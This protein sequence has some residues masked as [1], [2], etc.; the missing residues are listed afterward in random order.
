MEVA[1]RSSSPTCGAGLAAGVLVL[2]S[3]LFASPVLAQTGSRFYLGALAGP[4]YTDA[5]RVTGS[6]IAVG[7]TGGVRLSSWLG[8][9]VDVLRPSGLLTREYTGTSISFAGP[10]ASRDEIERL[11]VVTRFVNE[12]RPSAII[13]AGAT[14]GLPRPEGRMTPRLF[15]GITNQSARER[16]I[17]EHLSLPPGVTPEQVNRAI[18]PEVEGRSRQLGA[19]TVGGSLA[20]AV[21][22]HVSI[23]PDLRYDYGSI[24]D[25]I[26]NVV[27]SSVRVLWRF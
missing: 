11:A 23:A 25:E 15:A 13:S 12:R 27:R 24:G 21:T 2:S 7:V 6:L 18:P 22:P 9:E 4:F 10:G 3:L 5:D 8:V 20:I 1:F 17:R 26:N 16:T 19:I 14:F